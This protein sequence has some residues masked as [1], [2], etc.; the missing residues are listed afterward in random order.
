MVQPAVSVSELTTILDTS[1]ADLP[2]NSISMLLYYQ[3]LKSNISLDYQRKAANYMLDGLSL[4]GKT[5]VFNFIG[6]DVT[7]Y[8]DNSLLQIT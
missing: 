5:R 1:K 2:D 7:Q 3:S 8:Q 4:D 6:S